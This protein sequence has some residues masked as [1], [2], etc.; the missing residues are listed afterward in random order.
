VLNEQ[1]PSG[2]GVTSSALTVNMIHVY[3]QSLT[4]GTC[5]LLG[6]LPGVLTTTG[7]IVVGSAS[8]SVQ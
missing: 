1:I 7:E 6:C 5:T 4:G 2:D 3:L 8:S